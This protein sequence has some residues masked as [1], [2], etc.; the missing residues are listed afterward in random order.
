MIETGRRILEEEFIDMPIDWNEFLLALPDEERL[1]TRRLREIILETE[2]RLIEKRNY[3]VPY[4]ARNKQVCFI[5]PVSAPDAPNAK[6]QTTNGTL[7]SFGLCYGNLLSNEH[8]LLLAEGRK[9]VYIIRLRSFKELTTLEKSIVEI[10]HEAV[11][12]DE[13]S[14]Q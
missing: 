7:V 14:G 9:Q 10:I 13:L 1:I 12:V 5:W 3:G 6:N 4:Y 2:P 8:G 11:L